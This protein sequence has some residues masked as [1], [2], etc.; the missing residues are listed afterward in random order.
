M[1]SGLLAIVIA[2]LAASECVA[3]SIFLD[4]SN[5]KHSW[6]RLEGEIVKGDYERVVA[7]IRSSPDKF[8]SHSWQLNSPGGDVVEAMRI[9]DLLKDLYMTVNVADSKNPKSVCASA[10]FFIYVSALNRNAIVGSVGVHRPYFHPSYF[11]DLPP[12]AAEL[13]YQQ[14]SIQVRGYLQSRGVP[15]SLIARMFSMASNEAYWLTES[16]LDVV[17]SKPAWFDQYIL[18]RCGFN[19]RMF[20]ET[21]L[22]KGYAQAKEWANCEQKIMIEQGRLNIAK[23]LSGRH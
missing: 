9:G 20:F 2:F 5:P 11:S 16:E 7:L 14:Y 19:S 3:A 8:L 12:P 13:R 15:D 10:C 21:V 4:S 6:L 18:S 22:A 17:G 1:R 23:Y